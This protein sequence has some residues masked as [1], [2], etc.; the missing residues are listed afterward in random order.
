MFA[1]TLRSVQSF[2][3]VNFKK[4]IPLQ[5]EDEDDLNSDR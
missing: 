2:S 3:V 4:R 5:E 1:K